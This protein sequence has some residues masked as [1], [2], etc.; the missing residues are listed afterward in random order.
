MKGTGTAFGRHGG[1]LRNSL[2]QRDHSRPFGKLKKRPNKNRL[3]TGGF[4]VAVPWGLLKDSL[5]S[6]VRDGPW[7]AFG[8]LSSK[9]TRHF[10][11]APAR[12]LGTGLAGG[13]RPWGPKSSVFTTDFLLSPQKIHLSH[14]HN[15]LQPSVVGIYFAAAFDSKRPAAALRV[16]P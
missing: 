2:T 6:L 15:K 14:L 1:F 4:P 11:L 12:I 16:T 13:K 10:G 9:P 5:K 3:P 8:G 7:A